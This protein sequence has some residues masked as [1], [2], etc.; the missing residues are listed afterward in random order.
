MDLLQGVLVKVQGVNDLRLPATLINSIHTALVYH[1]HSTEATLKELN[2]YPAVQ[3][4]LLETRKIRA[5][6]MVVRTGQDLVKS[7]AAADALRS[8]GQR[9]APYFVEMLNKRT[10]S[11]TYAPFIAA[12]ELSRSGDP[13]STGVLISILNESADRQPGK[14]YWEQMGVFAWKS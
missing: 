10:S 3:N 5:L 4:A 1:P 7:Y 2:S 11:D 8:Y 14:D 9:A 12:M 6:I 13:E